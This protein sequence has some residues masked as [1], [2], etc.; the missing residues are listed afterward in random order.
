MYQR[1]ADIL[2]RRVAEQCCMGTTGLL[3]GPEGFITPV[4]ALTETRV[5]TYFLGLDLTCPPNWSTC[6]IGL[7]DHSQQSLCFSGRT[8]TGNGYLIANRHF[9]FGLRRSAAEC[10][11]L[12]GCVWEDANLGARSVSG[13]KFSQRIGPGLAPSH[14]VAPGSVVV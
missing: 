9:G 1:C 3:A 11:H 2:I 12:Q 14:V 7:L 5:G 6:D 10:R 8:V 13:S 4:R